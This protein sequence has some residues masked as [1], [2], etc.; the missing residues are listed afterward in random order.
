MAEWEAP[1]IQPLGINTHCSLNQGELQRGRGGH[2]WR[3]WFTADTQ[4]DLLH[5]ARNR[6]NRLSAPLVVEVVLLWQTARQGD[7]IHRRKWGG[8]ISVVLEELDGL[9]KTFSTDK[10][11]IFENWLEINCPFPLVHFPSLFSFSS[12]IP[13]LSS[14]YWRWQCLELVFPVS[15]WILF[16]VRADWQ[17]T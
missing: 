2:V 14:T 3:P 12:H 11:E 9:T 17:K 10:R 8:V 6:D 7:P 16:K 5:A 4:S 15:I 1:N 13:L